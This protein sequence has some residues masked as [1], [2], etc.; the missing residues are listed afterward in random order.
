M[1]VGTYEK[2]VVSNVLT[3]RVCSACTVKAMK[4]YLVCVELDLELL[5]YLHLVCGIIL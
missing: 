4:M 5:F 1:Y 3:F 2:P